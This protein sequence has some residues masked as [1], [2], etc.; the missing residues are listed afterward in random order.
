M[1]KETFIKDLKNKLTTGQ[2]DRRQFMTNALAAG[3]A[4][5][6]ATA[7]AD[8]VEA[9]TPTKGGTISLGMGHGATSDTLDPG[10]YE[11]GFQLAMTYSFNG[12][13]T[14]VGPDGNLAPSLAES[15]EG[16]NGAATWVFKLRKGLEFHNGRSVTTNDVI[17]SLNH[18]RGEDSTSGVKPLVATV[19]DMIA[20]D[21]HTL[22]VELEGGNADFPFILQDYHFTIQP[23]N[24]DGTLDWQSGIGCGAMTLDSYNA[25][26]SAEL[27]RFGNHFRDINLDGAQILS[28]IDPN[29][30]TA[31]IVSGDVDLIDRVDL[32]TAGLLGRKPGVNI[33]QTNGTQHYTFPMRTDSAPYDNADIRRG[34]KHVFDRQEL[35]DKILFGYGA[36]GNDIPLSPAQAQYN[37]NLEQRSYDPDKAKFYF[38][39]AGVDSMTFDLSA[40]DAAFSGAVDAAVLIQNSA[41]AAG[42]DINVIREPNDGYWGD[43]WMNKAWCA[44]YWG[45][46]P[47]ADLMFSTAYQG[48]VSWNDTFWANARFDELLVAARGELD[49][50]KRQGMYDEMQEILWD[51]GGVV[52]PMFASYVAAHNDSI[53]M[54][55]QRSSNWDLD[56]NRWAERWWKA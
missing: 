19:T 26:I 2:I 24:E 50:G 17:A 13:L 12:Y 52:I 33:L 39:K 37:S 21:D 36:V 4:V 35:V 45:G 42:I 9:A 31:A 23:A 44:C 54:P 3:V 8:K 38:K 16:S 32:K 56:G 27:S 14:E 29:A 40:A 25:G 28:L 11:N 22:R 46:R 51:D 34:L 1:S 47:T 18:H 49:A 20:E 55:E 30:R 15:W 7:F 5:G 48:G 6:T 41:K 53:M 43:V 10:I